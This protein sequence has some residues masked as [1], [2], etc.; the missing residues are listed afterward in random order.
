MER[1]S[2]GRMLWLLVWLLGMT[3]LQAGAADEPTQLQLPS[4]LQ[5]VS[6][7]GGDGSSCEKAVVIQNA[8]NNFEGVAA[9]KAWISWK[10]PK[11]KLKS[12]GLSGI[13][14]KTFDRLEIETAQGA[15]KTI[16]F[17]ITDFFGQW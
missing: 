15:S 2:M 12:Q 5:H 6:F 10:Y 11:A 13:G 1:S 14:N 9:E 16:C 8:A 3:V 17:D 7:T 4:K